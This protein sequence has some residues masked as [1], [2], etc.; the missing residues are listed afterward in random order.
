MFRGFGVE[1]HHRRDLRVD[2]LL[3]RSHQ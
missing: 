1:F 3:A 2:G